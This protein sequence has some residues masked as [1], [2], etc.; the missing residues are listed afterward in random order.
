MSIVSTSCPTTATAPGG[1]P[2]VVSDLGVPPWVNDLFAW[3]GAGPAVATP[4]VWSGPG[5]GGTRSDTLRFDGSG[6]A[7]VKLP[8][9]EYR[10]RLVGGGGGVVAVEEYSDELLPSRVTL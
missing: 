10:Y 1:A 8:P 6:R 9:G 5:V 2:R 3:A 4:V 7:P